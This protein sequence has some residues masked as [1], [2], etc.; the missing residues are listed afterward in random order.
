MKPLHLFIL[1]ALLAGPSAGAA[2][3][4]LAGQVTSER[5]GP[6]EGVVVSAKKA[7]STITISVVTDETGHYRFPAAK[8]GPGDY[9]L[10]IRAVGYDLASVGSITVPQD[11]PATA[12][13]K[14]RPTDDLAAQLSPAEWIASV[15][16]TEDQKKFLYNCSTCH[17]PERIVRSDHTAED[18]RDNV[19]ER[20]RGY[21]NSAWDKHP[22]TRLKPRDLARAFGSDADGI[23][24]YLASINLSATHQWAYA[25]KTLPRPTGRATHVVYTE[26]D[27]PRDM[28]QPHD[29]VV[30]DQGT[31]WFTEF[32]E[33]HLGRLDPKTG[34]IKEY[35]VPTLRPEE[36]TGTLDLEADQE[37]HIWISL[38]NQGGI[39]EF[40]E[41]SGKFKT[42]AV[43]K[44][45]QTEE[46][47]QSMVGPQHWEVDGKVWTND[48]SIPGLYRVDLKSGKWEMWAPYKDMKGT[49][50]VYGIYADKHNNIF[51]CDFGGENIGKIDAQSGKV[52]LYPT[53]TRH[54]RPRRGRMDDEG[55]LWFAEWRGD[56][57][58]MFDTESATFKEWPVPIPYTAPYDVVRDKNGDL[59][60]GGMNTDRIMRMNPT[61]GAMTQY[62]LPRSTNVRRVFVDNSTPIPTFWVGN[63]HGSS[64]VK[65]EALD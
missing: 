22:Q 61:S 54:S 56:K 4:L 57:I 58:A 39:A 34:K 48:T 35:D 62:L 65:L 19:L 15:P 7:G 52:T 6:M 14:L 42:F 60:S 12:D 5:E 24:D 8:I 55:H 33:Q 18:F 3:A 44:Q 47:Q 50:S 13:L 53:P 43:P 30:D 32:G 10:S 45:Y 1:S 23:A 49:H 51:F 31:V 29:V 26:Y 21:A 63:N 40:D 37:G 64:I 59:W 46:T 9:A 25:L 38:Q 17:S 11:K 36:P 27:V 16:G 20:M 41:K 28:T 2:E